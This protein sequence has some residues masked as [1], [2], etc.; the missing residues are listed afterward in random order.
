MNITTSC[1]IVSTRTNAEFDP[2]RDG[3]RK[4]QRRKRGGERERRERNGVGDKL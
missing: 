2:Q 3:A 1:F 4:E